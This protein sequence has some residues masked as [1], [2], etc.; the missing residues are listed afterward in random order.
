MNKTSLYIYLTEILGEALLQ[1]LYMII[2]PTIVA[3]ILGFIM[4]V[5]LVVTKPRGLKPNKTVYSILGFIVNM[6]RS[7]PFI[8]LLIA[9][10]P[11]TRFI[12]GTSIGETAA[13]V[14]ITIGAAPFIARVIET[15]LNEV[16]EGLIEAAKSFGAT[17]LQIIF[18]VIVK[19]A[20]PSIVSG[21]T[22]SIISI[23]GCT[24]MAGT[25]GAGGLGKVAIVYGHQRFD[26]SVMVYVVVTLII[27]VQIIQSAGDLAYKKLK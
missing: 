10:I 4:A 18:K 8:I 20:M 13:I 11:F 9:L 15:A 19:E 16:D 5:I 7:F 27:M 17:N 14:P 21:I 12:V 23:L 1:T 3:T 26:T 2:V 25:V 6:V 24:A 22:L